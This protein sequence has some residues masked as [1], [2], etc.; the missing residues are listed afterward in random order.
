MESRNPDNEMPD[1]RS[2]SVRLEQEG[3]A[4]N[5]EKPDTASAVTEEQATEMKATSDTTDDLVA[6][7]NEL[8]IKSLDDVKMVRKILHEYECGVIYG[9]CY[10]TYCTT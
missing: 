6:K 5:V 8:E 9:R 10:Q 2:L 3:G 4:P 7:L 1:G